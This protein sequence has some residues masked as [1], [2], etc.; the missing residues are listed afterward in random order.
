MSKYF[1]SEYVFS[2]FML[3]FLGL[4]TMGFIKLA[5]TVATVAITGFFGSV[6]AP[7][8]MAFKS[9][10]EKDKINNLKKEN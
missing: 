7:L 6:V 1:R 3:I 2:V 9:K 4:M 10:Y 5:P 8:V